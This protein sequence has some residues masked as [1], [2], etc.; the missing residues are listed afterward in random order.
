MDNKDAIA[1]LRV[2]LSY[3]KT[4]HGGNSQE[5]QDAVELGVIALRS[6]PDADANK[7]IRR[8]WDTNNRLAKAEELINAIEDDLDRGNDNDWARRRIAEWREQKEG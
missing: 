4:M 5:T 6:M 3:W 2:L 7:M 8:M 1:W